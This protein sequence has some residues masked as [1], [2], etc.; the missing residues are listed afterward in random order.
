M[1]MKKRSLALLLAVLLIAALTLSACASGGG[2]VAVIATDADSGTAKQVQ[3]AL[4]VKSTLCSGEEQAKN[5]ALKIYVGNS[6]CATAERYA[7]GLRDGDCWVRVTDEGIFIQG[8]SQEKLEEAAAYFA[9]TVAPYVDKDGSIAAPTEVSVE[10]GSYGRSKLQTL[11][12]DGQDIYLYSIVTRGGEETENARLI[13]RH[14]EAMSGYELPIVAPES[15]AEDTPAIIF[16]SSGARDAAA[17][18][19]ELEEKQFI[20]EAQGSSLYLC[21]YDEAEE[22]L[23]TYMFLGQTLGCNFYND[24]P[25]AAKLS[26]DEYRFKFTTAFDGSG[27]FKSMNTQVARFSAQNEFNILQGGCTDGEYAYYILQDQQLSSGNC[28]IIKL[29]IGTW[30]MEQI[31]EPLPLDHGN[32]ITY[33]PESNRLLVAHCDPDP[34][35]VSWVDADTLELIE[36]RTLPVPS[37]SY[38]YNAARQQFASYGVSKVMVI[39]DED[40]KPVCS[41]NGLASSLT[42]QGYDV[43]DNY[44]YIVNNGGNAINVCD[45]EG[46]WLESIPIGVKTEMENMISLGDIHYTSYLNAGSDIYLTIFYRTLVR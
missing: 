46:H 9:Q 19:A 45:W 10:Y 1:H 39:L 11:R 13:R 21:A 27:K 35:V 22:T 20:I 18:A 24:T 16:G 28:L 14:I 17:V 36:T 12:F 5:A 43:D 29:K 2:G 38:S 42:T 3:S 41:Y 31:S 34:K 25:A 4:K 30:E 8:A 26:F 23:L 15:L 44:V 6:G 40:L 32:G 37:Y 7:A 33:L